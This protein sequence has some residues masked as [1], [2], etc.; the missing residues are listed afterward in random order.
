VEFAEGRVVYF[1]R[2]NPLRALVVP[3]VAL[4][5]ALALGLFAGWEICRK[6]RLHYAPAVHYLFLALCLAPLGIASVAILR[7]APGNLTPV[8]RAPW[9]W[10]AAFLAGAAP[11]VWACVHPMRASH[12]ARR[13]LLYSWPVLILVLTQA[14]R[15][16]LLF[17]PSAYAD[18]PLAAPLPAPPSHT[19]VIW[20]IFDELSQ[21]TAFGNRRPDL[22][23]PNLDRLRAE[24]FYAASAKSPANR[25]E[26]ALPSLILGEEVLHAE[27]DGPGDLRVKLS[28]RAR[29][30]SWSSLPNVF[31]AARDLGFNTAV[32]GWFHPYGRVLNRSLT[33]CYWTAGWLS[34]GVEE[35]SSLEPLIEGMRDRVGLQFLAM[36]L[37]GHLPSVFP[38]SYNVREN[39]RRF[40][41]L[42]E[43]AREIVSDPTVGLA[44]IHLPIPHPPAIYD[45]VRG[46]F[47][48]ERRS[49]V[50]N[51]A[52]VD[53]EFGI[54]RQSM[55]LAGLWDSSAIVVS[56][57]HGWR[58]T[59]WRGTPVW[60]AE[61]EAAS[62]QDVTGV[63][64]LV[65]LPGRTSGLSYSRPFNTILTRRLITGILKGEVADAEAV[66][67]FID[68]AG[69]R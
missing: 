1:A 65:K 35:P 55:E 3:V 46:E 14:I 22:T 48:T 28:S 27:P 66:G 52:L 34:P 24:S 41:Y 37:V 44:L 13:V 15:V 29:M 61:D 10:P 16:S 4:E 63:P 45:K 8:V 43:R 59:L 5:L 69:A 26:I 50:D 33:K 67:S 19:R 62:Q 57:D 38:A 9:F 18:G 31:D 58:T 49:Y 54:L 56:A 60:T 32:V 64:F 23:L 21:T 2:L 47:T 7:V 17:P 11:L 53:R 36:P 51:V 39:L 25:T 42:R 30:A 20:I 6:T 40:A 12:F 68:K